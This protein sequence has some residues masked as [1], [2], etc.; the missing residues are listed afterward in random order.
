[1]RE[2]PNWFCA[3]E[4]RRSIEGAEIAAIIAEAAPRQHKNLPVEQPLATPP[5]GE[6][7]SREIRRSGGRS[8]AAV[9]RYDRTG[10]A[11]EVAVLRC[12]LLD[13]QHA[14]RQITSGLREL[15]LGAW[16]PDDGHSPPR[17]L[18]RE[19]QIETNRHAWADIQ[20]EWV[21]AALW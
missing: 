6:R 8:Y 4:Y 11:H 9:D 13:K 15:R 19:M 16:Q 2:G 12:D 5:C 10:S 7:L 14:D 21:S 1:M 18:C 3:T 20:D 17:W